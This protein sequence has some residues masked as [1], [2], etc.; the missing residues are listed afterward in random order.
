MAVSVAVLLPGFGSWVC[1]VTCTV[2]VKVAP[3]AAPAGMP[4]VTV[5]AGKLAFRARV[6]AA[7]VREQT[8][9]VSEVLQVQPG[10]AAV[11]VA[12][13]GGRSS[14]TRNGP[15][16]VSAPLLWTTTVQARFWPGTAL[17]VWVLVTV[18]SAESMNTVAVTG[19]SAYGR[20]AFPVAPVRSAAVT[21]RV[22]V[23]GTVEP[24][25]GSVTT[26]GCGVAE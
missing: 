2:L 26:A 8:T 23:C 15:V 4:V 11:A 12:M 24:T 20:T 13:P 18:T 5:I 16:A 10:P 21:S 17:P 3:S 14:T 25:P 19:G 6:S 1:A 9:W 22:L 7:L